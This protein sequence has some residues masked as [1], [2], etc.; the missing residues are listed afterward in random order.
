MPL[1]NF[2]RNLCKSFSAELRTEIVSWLPPIYWVPISSKFL[3]GNDSVICKN[4][5]RDLLFHIVCALHTVKLGYLFKEFIWLNRFIAQLNRILK[6][7]MRVVA[8][9]SWALGNGAQRSP[10]TFGKW[11]NCRPRRRRVGKLPQPVNGQNFL[12]QQK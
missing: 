12:Q 6:F 9:C 1:P 2:G 10:P 8:N 5:T 7:F 3:W 11:W 4:L